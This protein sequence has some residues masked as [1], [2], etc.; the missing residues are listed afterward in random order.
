LVVIFTATF[1][2]LL[3]LIAVKSNKK[4]PPK[5]K[6]RWSTN[7][8]LH[9]GMEF[10][11]HN[12]APWLRKRRL[13]ADEI[14]V[15]NNLDSYKVKLACPECGGIVSKRLSKI[16]NMFYYG[17]SNFPGCRFEAMDMNSIQPF[18]ILNIDE[19]KM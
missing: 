7:P 18:K 2:L 11:L 1:L 17:C 16:T 4:K 19:A 9:D 8:N 10:S 12:N 6:D 3:V 5:E 14:R 15:E 13:I